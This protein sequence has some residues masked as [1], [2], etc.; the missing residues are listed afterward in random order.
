MLE[1]P[2]WKYVLVT[3]VLL[4]ALLFALPN[5]FGEDPALQVE[6][7]NREPMDVFARQT[8]E[9][10]LRKQQIVIE[11]DYI[12]NG[13]L[14]FAFNDV[15]S[16]LKARDTVDATLAD[17]DRAALSTASRAP[18]WM[19]RLGLKAMP[20]G[21]DLRGGLYLL[22]QVDV[23]GAVSQLLES[24]EQ[25]FRRSLTEAKLTFSDIAPIN[26][27][28]T[29]NADGLRVTLPAQS[30]TAAVIEAL[31]KVD[32]TL[33]F[34]S[35]SGPAVEMVLTPAQI[36]AREDYA[37][38]QNRTTLM[39]RVNELGVSEPIVQRQGLDRINVQLPGVQNSAEVKDL[40]GKVA[41]LEFRL[42]DTQ[43]SPVQAEQSG[44]A[45]LGAKLYKRKDGSS[46]LLKREVVVTGDELTQATSTTTNEGPAVSIKLDAR[47]AESMQ[48]TT[49]LNVGK[50]LAV[51]YIEKSRRL[52][53]VDGKPVERETNTETVIN[54]ATIRGVFGPQ[55]EVTGLLA[56][57]ARDLSLLLR[58][59][60]LAAPVDVVEERAIGPSL[61]Q[62]NIDKGVRA[63]EIG[64]LAVFVFMAL[65]YH[66]FGL[67]AD[68]VLLANVV[69]LTALL[70]LLGASL[71]LP[72]IAGIILTV[73]I[74]VDA[75]VLIYERIREELRNGVSPQA[76][77]RAG[78]DKAF[79]AIAD[80]NVTALI[81]GLAL[82]VIGTGA[83]RG[84]AIVLTLGIATSMF[85]S[86]LGSRA[87]ISL[88]YGG[89]RKVLRLSIG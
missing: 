18:A 17:V 27:G 76:A 31:R 15:A 20:L 61:G 63:L 47:G 77:I 19:R 66:A 88:L 53:D 4:V 68:L 73:G 74:A 35:A 56:A 67:V 51:V 1:F 45:P 55:F 34:R 59:G 12:D 36:K 78:F 60:S 38:E 42:V 3:L 83:I 85:T 24:Y 58:S 16:Q 75:N 57:E 5:I 21:L 84:F 39:N 32:S 62:E 23:N 89:R 81:S 7:K 9:E 30:D 6:R 13:R 87:L 52:V 49:R 41:T 22:Y 40:L 79:S 25:S 72:G 71:S 50:P 80:S 2:R 10:L 82:W 65:Y 86:L 46:I 44:H 14:I 37:L 48:R 70:S 28:A 29:G 54:V 69:L 26:S 8:I 33:N 64:M 11:R 43:D